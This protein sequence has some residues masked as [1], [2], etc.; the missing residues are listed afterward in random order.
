M[1]R[2]MFKYQLVTRHGPAS[3]YLPSGAQVKHFGPD[4]AGRLCIWAQ[5]NP[6]AD[7]ESREFHVFFT[8]EDIPDG[9][10]HIMSCIDA[11]LMLHLYERA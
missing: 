1:N 6:K 11:P 7:K 8:G 5:V 9:Y 2:R 3:I 10:T 4:P